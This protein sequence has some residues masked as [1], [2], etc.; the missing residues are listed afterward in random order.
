[1]KRRSTRAGQNPALVVILGTIS[2]GGHAP[3]PAP[4]EPAAGPATAAAATAPETSPEDTERAAGEAGVLAPPAVDA[5]E[6]TGL[7]L[8]VVAVSAGLDRDAVEA[9]FARRG[10][11]LMRCFHGAL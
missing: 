8:T 11:E 6:A 10:P 5:P 7:G 9:V 4:A 1:M 3:G 2:C